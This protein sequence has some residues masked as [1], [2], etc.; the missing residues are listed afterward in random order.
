LQ[1]W[2]RLAGAKRKR[3]LVAVSWPGNRK[4][5]GVLLQRARKMNLKNSMPRTTSYSTTMTVRT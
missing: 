3:T 5:T 2:R 1:K 4:R